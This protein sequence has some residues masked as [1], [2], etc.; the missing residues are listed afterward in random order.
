MFVQTLSSKHT[1]LSNPSSAGPPI[2]SPDHE[3]TMSKVSERAPDQ[4]EWALLSQIAQ[5]I[6]GVFTYLAPD[7]E[8]SLSVLSHNAEQ[9]KN[10]QAAT[11]FSGSYLQYPWTRPQ[12]IEYVMVRDTA[13]IL[14]GK[15]W[16]VCS[17]FNEEADLD[18]IAAGRHMLRIS[19]QTQSLVLAS[20]S[21][22]DKLRAFRGAVLCIQSV[23]LHHE[24]STKWPQLH[25][26][27]EY[28]GLVPPLFSHVKALVRKYENNRAALGLPLRLCELVH[29][30]AS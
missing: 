18:G 3:E 4:G 7:T 26:F 11:H 30:C 13:M 16:L 27:P 22:E 12:N 2:I 28:G 29:S 20:L 24:N 19:E 5:R 1:P 15:G 14:V 23:F 17:E 21:V 25:V 9:I 8:I 6:L 10:P